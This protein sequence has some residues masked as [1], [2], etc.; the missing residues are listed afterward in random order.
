MKG[1]LVP[2]TLAVLLS[3]LLSPVCDRLERWRF[4]RIPAVLVTALL[5][6]TMLGVVSWMAVVQ[7]TNLAP[8][9]PEY[10][11][12][13]QAKLHATNEYVGDLLT[14]ITRHVQPL[15]EDLG[16][17][18]RVTGERSELYKATNEVTTDEIFFW[19]K[20]LTRS[21]FAFADGLEA[22]SR[23][24]CGLQHLHDLRGSLLGQRLVRRELRAADRDVVRIA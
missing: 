9:M 3:F 2:L 1:V 22:I 7:M 5:A 4:G 11:A 8:K 20:C 21:L 15:R 24:A 6:F 19:Y 12:N 14:K 17:F 23:H 18:A 13:I 10:Q 16:Y